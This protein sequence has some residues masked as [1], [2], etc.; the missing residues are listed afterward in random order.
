MESNISTPANQGVSKAEKMRRYNQMIGSRYANDVTSC[1]CE[2]P[3]RPDNWSDDSWQKYKLMMA[4]LPCE[5]CGWAGRSRFAMH[6]PDVF[7]SKESVR[8]TASSRKKPEGKAG[9]HRGHHAGKPEYRVG[10]FPLLV[11]FD[12]RGLVL[13][14]WAGRKQW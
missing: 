8:V 10:G 4:R 7:V 2:L 3:E 14:F 13:C 1:T 9:H 6:P 11:H 5:T 12:I